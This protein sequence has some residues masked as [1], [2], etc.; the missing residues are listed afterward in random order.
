MRRESCLTNLLFVTN[1]CYESIT[2]YSSFVNLDDNIISYTPFLCS[3]AGLW[4]HAQ[5]H[6]KGMDFW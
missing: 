6:P 3:D 4:I 2:V 5:W 1:F